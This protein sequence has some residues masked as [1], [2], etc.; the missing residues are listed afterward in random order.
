VSDAD[1]E[2]LLIADG[3]SC[4]TQIEQLSDRRAL[5]TAQVIEMALDHGPSGTPGPRPEREYPVVR[6]NGRVHPPGSWRV[7]PRQAMRRRT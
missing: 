7:A 5:H 1:T 6:L 3:F 2:T 4:K